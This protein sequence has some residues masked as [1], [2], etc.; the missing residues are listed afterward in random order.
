MLARPTRGIT[1]GDRVS[2]VPLGNHAGLR[3]EQRA[4]GDVVA[5]RRAEPAR[6]E[7]RSTF[8]E[9][10]FARVNGAVQAEVRLLPAERPLPPR[11]KAPLV[12]RRRCPRVAGT[13]SR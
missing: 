13:P 12:D 8:V 3:T 11:G 4:L 7:A 6:L 2:I 5:A 10:R 9:S 1:G